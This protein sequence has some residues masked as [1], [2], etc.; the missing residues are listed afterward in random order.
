MRSVH[1]PLAALV[2][3]ATFAASGTT[4]AQ[5]AGPEDWPCIQV[6]VPEVAAATLWARP[7]DPV[8]VQGWR[9]DGELAALAR[10]LGTLEAPVDAPAGALGD[11]EI[12]AIDAWVAGTPPAA[13]A[14]RL[15]AL[16][17]GTV[18]TANER[19]ARFID[20]I[21]RYTRQQIAIAGQ[22]EASLNELARLGQ[23][24]LAGLPEQRNEAQAT[25]AWHERL[26]DQRE[27]AIRALCEQPVVLEETLFTVVRELQ[28][29]LPES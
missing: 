21:R 19:R 11:A 20:G 18:A 14:R 29:R 25:L 7:L 13:L 10:R 4:R 5:P 12:A 6:L 23:G 8:T 3:L 2:A 22:I 17:A 24:S 16:V 1:A 27:R 28:A 15:D 26:Y 9:E